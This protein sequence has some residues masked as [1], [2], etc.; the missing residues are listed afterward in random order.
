MQDDMQHRQISIAFS[1]DEESCEA[2]ISML[3][4]AVDNGCDD[5]TN[6]A[7]VEIYEST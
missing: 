2:F 1:G 7:G 5:I 4:E 6:L 3:H